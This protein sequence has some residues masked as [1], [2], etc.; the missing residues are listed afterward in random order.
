MGHVRNTLALS[1]AQCSGPPLSALHNDSSE[2]AGAHGSLSDETFAA[3]EVKVLPMRFAAG[4]GW[5]GG[6]S[7][8]HGCAQAGQHAQHADMA[9]SPVLAVLCLMTNLRQPSSQV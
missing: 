5:A 8:K 6:S 4:E 2:R 7:L 9:A 1:A 3:C